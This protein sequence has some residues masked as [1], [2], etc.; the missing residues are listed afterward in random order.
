MRHSAGLVGDAGVTCFG[1]A[2]VGYPWKGIEAAAF[3]V[4]S[5]DVGSWE[6]AGV[7]NS[8]PHSRLRKQDRS[9][10]IGLFVCKTLRS[11]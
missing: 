3:I 6:Y 7:Y 10:S 5:F 8:W 9:I 1:L 11:S 2:R 4:T